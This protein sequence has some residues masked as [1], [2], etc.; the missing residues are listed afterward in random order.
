MAFFER[1]IEIGTLRTIGMRKVEIYQLLY[2]EAAIIGA[3]GTLAGLAF[4]TALILTAAHI[5]IP[6]GSFINQQVRPTL[7]AISLAISP[8]NSF[9]SNV[10]CT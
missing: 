1:I 3:I 4:E 5:G 9:D 10:L 6:L 7:T 2:S 8:H